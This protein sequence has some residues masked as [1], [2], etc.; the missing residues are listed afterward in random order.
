MAYIAL[1]VMGCVL[2][3]LLDRS[4][5]RENQKAHRRNLEI[6]NG[7]AANVGRIKLA[8]EAA[9]RN[10]DG[11]RSAQDRIRRKLELVRTDQK[12][13]GLLVAGTRDA[14]AAQGRERTAESNRLLGRIDFVGR[15]INE[16]TL[17][18]VALRDSVASLDASTD[19][20]VTSLAQLLSDIDALAELSRASFDAVNENISVTASESAHRDNAASVA[21]NDIRT[22]EHSRS[23][24]KKLVTDMAS[25]LSLYSSHSG[26]IHSGIPEG[27][28]APPRVL[29]EL[30]QHIHASETP[31]SIVEFGSGT[32]TYWI[33]RALQ[34]R[35]GGKLVSFEHLPE[36]FNRT[37]N[38]LVA[39]GL[40]D[41]VDLRLAPLVE[42]DFMG[43]S[44]R[45]YQGWEDLSSIDVVFVD[46]PPQSTGEAARMPAAVA[47]A[48]ALNLGAIV[49]LDDADRDD[50]RASIEAWKS[51]DYSNGSL[52][53][54]GRVDRAAF[55]EVQPNQTQA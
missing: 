1:C 21:V 7:V 35:G 54:V 28:S 27:W 22:G 39:A 47:L 13:S 23:L 36:Y 2:F 8:E 9:A 3:G 49:C 25:L 12:S 46:G 10:L 38:L 44:M 34:R 40:E 15:R 42:Q 16:Q 43:R 5:E 51:L 31:P 6:L 4:A 30:T 19:R 53:E 33:A 37:R 18:Q 41:H 14:L 29:V 45:W 48:G 20:Q 11:L 17:K 50:E 24:R 26:D 32:S 52:V 55:F